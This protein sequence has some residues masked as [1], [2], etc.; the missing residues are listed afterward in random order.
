[1]LN[2]PHIAPG[3]SFAHVW[4]T[5]SRTF[6]A[7]FGCGVSPKGCQECAVVSEDVGNFL[8]CVVVVRVLLLKVA[9]DVSL[10]P[11]LG[12][13]THSHVRNKEEDLGTG[14]NSL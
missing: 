5:A 3:P 6:P 10:A 4:S 2:G 9:D 11:L 8:V 14:G 7:V 12:D 1:M 13:K